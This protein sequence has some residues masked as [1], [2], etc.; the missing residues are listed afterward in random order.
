MEDDLVDLV[1]G[2]G[3]HLLYLVALSWSE[4]KAQ[5]SKIRFVGGAGASTQTEFM[6]WLP[7]SQTT[8]CHEIQRITRNSFPNK[9]SSLLFF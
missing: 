9:L 8:R 5:V 1:V 7:L 6:C 2:I 4:T 3:G